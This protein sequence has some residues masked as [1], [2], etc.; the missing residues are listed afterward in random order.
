MSLRQAPGGN[1]N[2][3]LGWTQSQSQ[4]SNPIGKRQFAKENANKVFEGESAS[5]K[6]SKTFV[7]NVGGNESKLPFG[8]ISQNSSSIR[9]NRPPGG[10]SSF[11]FA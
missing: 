9:V 5:K 3:S 4:S 8:E 2:F 10:D 1:S 11:R 7:Q 6:A